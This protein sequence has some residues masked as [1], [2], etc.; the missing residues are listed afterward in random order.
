MTIEQL[1][2]IFLRDKLLHGIQGFA[3]DAAD[4]G[5]ACPGAGHKPGILKFL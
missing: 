4:K 2:Q 3:V 5:L 1:I